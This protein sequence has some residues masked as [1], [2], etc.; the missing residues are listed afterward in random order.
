MR[1]RL[2]VLWVSLLCLC[3]LALP[4][5]GG[6]PSAADEEG[7]KAP[8]VVADPA[9]KFYKTWMLAAMRSQNLTFVGDF[10]MFMDN[11]DG[12]IPTM[13]IEKGG[14]GSISFGDESRSLTWELKDD[15]TISVKPEKQAE[16]ESGKD[17]DDDATDDASDEASD[18]ATD[19]DAAIE[20]AEVSVDTFDT[21]DF[22]YGDDDL[23]AHYEDEESSF[24]MIFN[25]SGSLADEPEIDLA[26]AENFT[27]LDELVGTWNL[28]AI[29]LAGSTIYGDP[30][31]LAA[32]YADNSQSAVFEVADDGSATLLD[33]SCNCTAGEDGVIIDFVF[34]Q[35]PIKHV[36]DYVIVDMSD[37][38]GAEMAFCFTK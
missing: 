35:L 25:E 4:A 29:K 9:E 8:A 22:V 33:Q 26:N 1:K 30:A 3:G 16:A 14:T 24:E 21:L 23:T 34:Y 18:D 32:I 10:S 5:C 37:L 17:A 27:S 2:L 13:V 15:N 38:F 28:T 7:A 19:N 6:S 20:D 36:G 11:E 31:D 12:Q